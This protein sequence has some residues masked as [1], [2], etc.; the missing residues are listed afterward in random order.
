MFFSLIEKR[1]SIRQFQEKPV[2]PEKIDQLVEAALSEAVEL[3]AIK[4]VAFLKRPPKVEALSSGV[5]KLLDCANV[6]DGKTR[7]DQVPVLVW[8]DLG[9]P[10]PQ[11]IAVTPSLL[12]PEEQQAQLF[13]PRPRQVRQD[14]LQCI[15]IDRDLF[16]AG[17]DTKMKADIF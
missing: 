13:I 10:E 14:F 11:A 6:P 1:R 16:D 15:N 2:E 4:L 17:H 9:K 3:Q 8:K 5:E 12:S 7:V